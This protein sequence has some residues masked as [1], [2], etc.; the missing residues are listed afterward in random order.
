MSLF[1]HNM[2]GGL[3]VHLCIFYR[4]KKVVY[5]SLY[6]KLQLTLQSC[7]L[8]NVAGHLHFPKLALVLTHLHRDHNF[9]VNRRSREQ[10]GLKVF[11]NCI[12]TKT[13]LRQWMRPNSWKKGELFLSAARHMTTPELHFHTTRS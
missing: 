9:I 2:Q 13:S 7:H 10:A 4:C 5:K 3:A 11:A 8:S 6:H 12:T 1:T